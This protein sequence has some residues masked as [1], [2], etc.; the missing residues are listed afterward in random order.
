MKSSSLEPKRACRVCALTFRLGGDLAQQYLLVR[1][2]GELAP[3]RG[4]HALA[5]GG[6][7]LGAGGHP[8]RTLLA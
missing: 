5:G 7:R 1:A 6:R 3:G 4:E 8:V 2:R